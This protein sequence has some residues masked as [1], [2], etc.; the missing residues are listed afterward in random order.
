MLRV[1]AEKK[2]GTVVTGMVDSSVGIAAALHVAAAADHLAGACG[3]GTLDLLAH[4]VAGEPLRIENGAMLLPDG[5][6]RGVRLDEKA[7]GRLRGGG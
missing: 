7:L 5:P 1:A 4:D 6:G 3:L 2:L